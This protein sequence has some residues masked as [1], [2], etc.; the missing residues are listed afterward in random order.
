MDKE[1]LEELKKLCEDATPGP[2]EHRV[3]QNGVQSFVQAPRNNPGDPYD[4]EIMG[5]DR[6]VDNYPPSQALADGNFIAA[7]RTALPELI[8]EVEFL[9]KVAEQ[10]RELLGDVWI[11]TSRLLIVS[12]VGYSS[13]IH[14]RPELAQY[15]KRG[16]E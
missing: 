1:R 5:E 6:N 15:L 12:E 10:M 3:L 16:K 4:I 14:G 8:A 11:D 2:W 13:E 9:T 7:S